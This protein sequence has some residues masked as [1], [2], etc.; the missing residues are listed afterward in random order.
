[1]QIREIRVFSFYF[2]GFVAQFNGSMTRVFIL[3]AL[4]LAAEISARADLVKSSI[5]ESNVAYLLVGGVGKNLPAEI[6]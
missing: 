2:S 3:A 1:M 5:L 4:V 6:P